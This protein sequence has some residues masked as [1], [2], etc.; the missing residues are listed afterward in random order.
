MERTNLIKYVGIS[1]LLAMTCCAPAYARSL[2]SIRVTEHA[3][4]P[5]VQPSW[6]V[7]SEPNQLFYVQRSPNSNTI[8]YVAKFDSAGNIGLGSI[9]PYWRRYNTTGEK[10]DLSTIEYQLA[11]G[12]NVHSEA[13][14][15]MLTISPKALSK[16]KAKL[17][18]TAPHKAEVRIVLGGR[19]A[20]LVYVYVNVDES[21]TIPRVTDISVFGIDI[22]TKKVIQ[23]TFRVNGGT[24]K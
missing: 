9:V 4:V 16:I 15:N 23:E 2:E 10:K 7:P 19:D 11:F 14:P 17:V 8:V 21:K 5:R 1:L 22:E 18:Q 6:P 3:S 12:F 20:K 13:T 24:L